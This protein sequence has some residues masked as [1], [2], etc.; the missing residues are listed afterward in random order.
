M[1]VKWSRSLLVRVQF[2]VV[3][4]SNESFITVLVG[5]RSQNAELIDAYSKTWQYN[6]WGRE[7][8]YSKP[9]DL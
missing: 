3:Y 6:W 2:R 9:I 8:C 5:G 1:P 7:G 4:S